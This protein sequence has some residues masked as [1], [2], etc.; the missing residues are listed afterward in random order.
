MLIVLVIV[1]VF[2]LSVA[3]QD[4]KDRDNYVGPQLLN[5][6]SIF[7]PDEAAL[8]GLGG[9][10]RVRVS[11]DENGNVTSVEQV[12]G[13]GWTCSQVTR[14]DVVAMREAATKAAQLAKFKPATYNWV[15]RPS[16]I[17]I[18]FDF[19]G[20]ESMEAKTVS[21]GTTDRTANTRLDQN[22]ASVKGKSIVSPLN[23]DPL[24]VEFPGP[25][26]PVKQNDKVMA[27]KSVGRHPV[28]SGGVMNGKALNLV[29]PQW[30]AV[31][32]GIAGT[33]TVQVLID[34]DGEVFGA[35]SINGHPLF[36]AVSTS[37]A[38]Q[39][40][41]LPT[42]LSGAPVRTFGVIVYR[43]LGPDDSSTN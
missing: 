11:V 24:S 40:T 5:T 8:S 21:F 33:V 29:K 38:C 7:I 17:S 3:A 37:A 22:R 20:E 32:K 27:S 14:P 16:S 41:F 6:P 13:P 30:P 25:I 26:I 12:T 18:N 19:P 9:L 23:G 15:A 28:I 34:S 39:S 10:V 35:K 43:F 2:C 1:E 36:R 31:A 4:D 42:T